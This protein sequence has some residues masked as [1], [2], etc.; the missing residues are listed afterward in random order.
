MILGAPGEAL[1]KSFEKLRL[2]SYQDQRGIWT[3]GW[4]HTGKDVGP[5]TQCTPEM[6]ELW[7]HGDIAAA[8]SGVS[9]TVLVPVSQNQTDALTSFTFNVGVGAEAHSTLIRLLNAGDTPGA[10][11]QFLV[12]SKTGGVTNPGLLRRRTAERELFLS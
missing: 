10:A 9:R 2:F 8:L 11:A 7:F 1:I 5:G 6:A 12:W 3:C 4:G